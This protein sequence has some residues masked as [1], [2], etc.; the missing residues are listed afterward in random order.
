MFFFNICNNKIKQE[1]IN[2]DNNDNE[3][4]IEKLEPIP[5][6]LN[7]I[8]KSI[9]REETIQ[10]YI[11]IFKIIYKKYHNE[12]FDE[13]ELEKI[14]RNQ[15]YNISK[16]NKQLNFIRKDLFNVIKQN[17][18]YINVIYAIITRLKYFDKTVRELYPY[19]KTKNDIYDEKRITKTPDENVSQ[20]IKELSFDKNDI[21]EK[22]NN[23]KLDNDEKLIYGLFTLL[24]KM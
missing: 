21:L 23:S 22:I 24:S 18:K 7:P 16:L 19:L 1:T 5:K 20:K 10:N 8:N 2:I 17:Y 3:I 13:T 14:L 9:L 6:R 15:S 11:N 4:I 12:D